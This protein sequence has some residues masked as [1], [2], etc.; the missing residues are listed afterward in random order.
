M[1]VEAKKWNRTILRIK[2][3]IIGILWAAVVL[4]TTAPA[5]ADNPQWD[6]GPV[7][8]HKL[9][10]KV[11]NPRQQDDFFDW[12]NLARDIIALKR[13]ETLTR[14]KLEAATASLEAFGHVRTEVDAL[15]RGAVVSILLLP[16]QRIKSIDIKGVYPLFERDIRNLMT[17]AP[18]DIYNPGTIK[19]QA[20]L[21][22]QRYR[23]EGYIA[24][25]VNI[26]WEH[27]DA[28]GH[29]DIRIHIQKGD[30]YSL[31]RLKLT[32]NQA[33][34]DALVL[35]LLSTWRS[36]TVWQG[37][38]RWVESRL[39]QDID[40]IETYYR[41]QGYADV[42]IEYAIT[43][44]DPANKTV[45]VRV[46]IDEGRR[47]TIEYAGNRHFSE[48]TL[49]K[50]LAVF[51]KGNRGNIG[52]RRTVQNIR[53]RYLKA[54]FAD[55]HVQWQEIPQED[56]QS[57]E[58]HVRIEIQ[59]GKQH[60]V[61][62]MIIT[63]NRAVSTETIGAQLLTRPPQ[64][65]SQGV[66]VPAVLTEDM[67]AVVGLYHK[68]GYQDARIT[69]K[70]D[71]EPKTH[72][73]TVTLTIDEGSQIRVGDIRIEG[74]TPIPGDQLSSALPLKSGDVFQPQIIGEGENE[75]SARIAAKGCP[76]VQVQHRVDI[77]EDRTRADI[78]YN[79]DSG[80]QVDIGRIFWAGNFRTR[81]TLLRR[82]IKLDEGEPFSLVRVL[83][84]Q[85]RLRD[86]DLFQS[87][88]IRSIGLKERA[89]KVHL[90]VTMVEKPAYFF[91]LGTGFRTDKGFYGRTK[92]GD[93]NFLGLNK[94]LRMG[95]EISGIGYRWDAGL[96]EPSFRG[97]RIS[98]DFG[99][100]TERREEFNQD[101]GTDTTGGHLT[102]SRPWGKRL[103]TALGIRYE[104]RE[105]FLR[106]KDAATTDVD[107]ET[108]EPRTIW[109][110]SPAVRYD[111]RDSFIRPRR[112]HL[113]SLI[114]DISKGLDSSLDD[115]VRYKV[116]LRTYLTPR[117]RLTLAGHALA[118]YLQ[119]YGVD[120]QIPED[121]LF[122][123]GGTNDVRGFG[124]NLLRFNDDKDPVGGQLAMAGS[125]EA[126]YALTQS[127]E[128]TL[129]VDTGTVRQ[130]LSSDDDG[131]EQ[132]QWTSGLGLRYIT[133]IGPIGLLYGHK[134]DPRPGESDGQ[135]H[136]SIGYTF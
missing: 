80:P 117:D 39:K 60:I 94:E 133:P 122:F 64:G 34:P 92:V 74:D 125:I 50:D 136:F 65:L 52:L 27:D 51:E 102:F 30:A 28:D 79:I 130:A 10:I 87:V 13:G 3:M 67:T 83:A 45:E 44:Q 54:G 12:D 121:Q 33:M 68:Y 53:R 18:G 84:A 38:S 58:R 118:G 128:L 11:E 1:T 7:T 93:R 124:E 56:D 49:K 129:F 59:E 76:H 120:G 15:D 132:W 36:A 134:L 101:F 9:N 116:D 61:R 77:T 105:Q 96:V 86:L 2:A 103:F 8:I 112:G 100:F 25:Q 32:G 63:G 99:V 4:H 98:A 43:N 5:M 69:E 46:E 95:G 21:I 126:R 91:E 20:G 6:G 88:Q 82:E 35:G 19:D 89:A 70:V 48:N 24:P 37:A 114:V 106:E 110:T 104:R 40:T 85:R 109:V 81:N 41:G 29:V 71:V 22:A 26:T 135:F 108:L 23:K 127:W 14:Q 113:A 62:E 119:P 17:I 66:F 75:L 73:V 78:V 131:K 47:Y 42:N 16:Y 115:F 57:T 31:G 123:L 111:S 97:T 90:L 55:V 107:P 72:Q